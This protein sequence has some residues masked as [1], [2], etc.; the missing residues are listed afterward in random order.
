MCTD[1]G[2]SRMDLAPR[3]G[4]AC[5]FTVPDFPAR[6]AAI[7]GRVDNDP[8]F[9]TF[10]SMHRAA[11]APPKAGA[12][13]TGIA[14]SLG[15]RLLET[16]EVTA[17]LTL[18]PAEDDPFRG[19]PVI[20]TDPA[21]M[22]RVRGMR[23]G[24]SPVLA[25]LEPAV[26]AGHR[27][28]ALVGIPCQVHALRAIEAEL[29]LERLLVIGTPC[30]DNTTIEN[31]HAFLARLTDRPKRVTYLEFRADYRVEMRFEDGAVR[32][33]PF[34]KLPLSDLPPDFFPL[35]C[36]TCTDYANRLADITVGYMGG[37]G[38]QWVIVRNARGRDMLAALGDEIALRPLTSKGKRAGAV[39]GFAANTERAAGGLPLRK[40]PD[41][42]RPIVAWLQPRIGPRGMEFARARLE[43]K[44]VETILHLR[45][46][47]PGRMKHMVPDH[48][49]RLAAP[50]DLTP[51]PGER[52]DKASSDQPKTP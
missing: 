45:R 21:D 4:T 23:M 52:Q 15:A 51:E 26:A 13:W 47:A 9:G 36:R 41:W 50:Y 11:M 17:V 1:C 35:T 14:S 24:F 22:E 10:L 12:Q 16:G 32:T 39:K 29:G 27:R 43:M 31:F 6:E 37:D 48:V 25:L 2:L 8:H 20:V 7:H 5:Q 3:C 38:D 34:L 44:A 28:I 42:L 40:M 49:W 30:S 46:A 18:A 33:I 19:V